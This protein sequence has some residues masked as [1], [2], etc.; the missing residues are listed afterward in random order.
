M[1]H[2]TDNE[3]Y[4]LSSVDNALSIMN[5]YLKY[6][7]LS[8]TE[9]AKLMDISRSTAFRF[10]VTLENRGFLRKT[11]NGKYRLGLNMFSLG[12]LAHNRMEI[13]GIVRPYLERMAN[14]TGESCHIAIIEDNKEVVFL[15]RAIGSHSL[16]MDTPLGYRMK[17]HNT[18]TGK[19]ILAFQDDKTITQYLRNATFEKTTSNSIA[20]VQQLLQILD[21]VKKNG[22]A[23][24]NEEAEYGL[25]CL[26][27]PLI[28]RDGNAYAAISVSGPTTRILEQKDFILQ[29]LEICVDEINQNV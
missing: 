3:R 5:L 7:E 21:Q 9:I 4:I 2:T 6:E 27:R 15:D 20:D 24:D 22:Y 26:A 11:E 8:T 17:A 19:A 12:M 10:I 25:T 29:Q 1:E 14:V 18:A 13:V 23:C 16:K 28:H